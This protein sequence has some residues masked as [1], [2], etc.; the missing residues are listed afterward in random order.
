MAIIAVDMDE[1]VADALDEHLSRYN[2]L[3][4][5]GVTKDHLTGRHLRDVIPYEHRQETEQIVHSEDFFADLKVMSGAQEVLKALSQEYEIFITTA[6]MEVP[7]SFTAK[8]E[9]LGKHFPFISP[10]NYV[11]CGSKHIIAA[12]YLID[13]NVRHFKLF[14]GKGILFDA[15]HNRQVT[16]YTRVKDWQDVAR[17]FASIPVCR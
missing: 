6:A 16:G 11:F 4:N 15:P 3:Y 5:A 13:D 7:K 14:K 2:A 9:W 8:Y 17:L 12:D 10:M 1:V